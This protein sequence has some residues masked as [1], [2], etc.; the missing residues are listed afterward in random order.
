MARLKSEVPLEKAQS[1]SRPGKEN[2]QRK[3]LSEGSANLQQPEQGRFKLV[4]A[5]A[6]D[7]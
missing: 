5:L 2:E 7:Y 1:A 4:L 6:C 3:Q